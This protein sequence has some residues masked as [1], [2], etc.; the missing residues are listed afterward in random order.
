MN[1]QLT[2]FVK[3]SFFS[4][5]IDFEWFDE[6]KWQN[7]SRY[8]IVKSPLHN[9]SLY[10]NSTCNKIAITNEEQFRAKTS[11]LL[12]IR[13]FES[14]K[15]KNNIRIPTTTG[16]KKDLNRLCKMPLCIHDLSWN[17]FRSNHGTITTVWVEQCWSHLV[18]ELD[19]VIIVSR[20]KHA[21]AHLINTGRQTPL[22]WRSFHRQWTR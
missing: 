1:Q 3:R 21:I 13:N 2:K 18:P 17:K 12:C 22:I 20:N 6:A 4:Y 8:G 9:L 16:E 19:S 14:S 5:Q 11:L 10:F 7:A 15:V